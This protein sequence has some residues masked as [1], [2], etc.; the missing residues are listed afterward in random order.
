MMLSAHGVT[1]TGRVRTTNEDAL[2]W[3]VGLGLFVIADG[4]GGHN[5]GEVASQL[6]VDVVREFIAKSETDT[7]ATMPY[8]VNAQ[9]SQEGNRVATALKL[10]NATVFATSQANP[11]Y[12][13][14]GTTA[15]V[16]VIR[17]GRLT[18]AGIGDSRIYSWLN[19]QLT[20]LTQ[21]DS[22][23]ERM[24]LE[25]PGISQAV[26]D[27]TPL[28]HVLTNVI[29]ANPETVVRVQERRLEDGE[30]LIICSD[31]LYGPLDG[32]PLAAL[33]AEPASLEQK[34]Q[35]LLLSALDAGSRDNATVLLVQFRS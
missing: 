6:C 4:M 19:G 29:G 26:L 22:W 20:Q 3:D 8:G 14:M 24:K 17:D 15:A 27:S 13:G 10:A 21:D 35:K 31:G 16:A 18:F 23:V 9:L 34:A 1:D 12:S 5:A 7:E 33:M 25:H 2:F 28:R 11:S 32:A 30:V